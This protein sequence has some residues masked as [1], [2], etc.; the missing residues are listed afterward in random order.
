MMI[1]SIY[2]CEE[3]FVR[4]RIAQDMKIDNTPTDEIRVNLHATMLAMDRIRGFLGFPIQVLSGYR[5]LALNTLVHGARD[6]QH[7]V[8][9]ACDFICPE[10]GAPRYIASILSAQMRP[11]GIDQ[12][13]MEGTWVHVSFSPTPRNEILSFRD[14]RYIK[15]IV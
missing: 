10:F 8:G 5:C 11:F 14:G 4:S 6:S 3:E 13:I 15:G 2:F 9:Q 7:M 12:M 1:Q